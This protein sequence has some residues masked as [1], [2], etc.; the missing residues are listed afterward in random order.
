MTLVSTAVLVVG[1]GLGVFVVAAAFGAGRVKVL[2]SAAQ[3]Q[4]VE[5]AALVNADQLPEP[6]P[7]A[8]GQTAQVLGASGGF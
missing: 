7:V 8:Q 3:D 6:L 4:S 1:L 2:D 5:L